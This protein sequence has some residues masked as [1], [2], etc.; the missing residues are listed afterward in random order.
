VPVR[1]RV[2]AGVALWLPL[3]LLVVVS[4][5]AVGPMRPTTTALLAVLAVALSLYSGAVAVGVGTLVPRF[6]AVRSFGVETVSPTA[7]ALFGHGFA[8]AL[9]AGIGFAAVALPRTVFEAGPAS[10]VGALL[11]ACLLLFLPAVAGYRYA[12]YRLATF[13]YD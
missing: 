2:L 7:W 11:A 5:G 1:G 10:S 6:R 3:T 13:T 4:V 8:V 9:G 12:V